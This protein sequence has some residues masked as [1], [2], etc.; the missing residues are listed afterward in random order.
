MNTIEKIKVLGAGSKYDACSCYPTFTKNSNQNRIGST[1]GCSIAHSATPD[2]KQVSL[3][4][5]LYGNSCTHDCKYCQNSTTCKNPAKKTMFEEE[6]L[7]K[8]FMS[9][10]MRNYVEGI[11]LSSAIIKNSDYTSEKMIST[12]NLLRNKY[13]FHGYVH[14]KVLPGTN[15]D[16]VKQATQ[17]ADRVSINIEAPN[18]SRLNDLSDVKDFKIDIQRR[19]QWIAKTAPKGGHSTQLV[20]GGSD[21][22]DFEILKTINTEYEELKLKKAYYSAFS[23]AKDTQLENKSAT[24]LERERKLYNTDFLLRVY[25]YKFDD[26]K[27]IMVNGM[28]PKGDPKTHV[29]RENFD[30]AVDINEANYKELIRVPGIGVNSALKICNLQKNKEKITKYEQLHNIGVVL[31]R[32]KPF[33]EVNGKRQCMLGEFGV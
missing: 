25:K 23:P 17:V 13:K 24:P 7:A 10:Y 15:R 19:Q 8:T 29:A 3:F 18:K 27:S 4:K 21:E 5:L 14:L 26:F 12:I 2:G 32:A 1:I 6:E 30:G 22:T 31:K 33:I 9:L 16:L 11:F 20:I 28:L